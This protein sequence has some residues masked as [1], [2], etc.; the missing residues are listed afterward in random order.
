MGKVSIDIDDEL[1]AAIAAGQI[2]LAALVRAGIARDAG[3]SAAMWRR[4]EAEHAGAIDA[5]NERVAAEGV[6]SDGLRTF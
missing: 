4:W 2:D 1:A 5:Y 6:W 3:P